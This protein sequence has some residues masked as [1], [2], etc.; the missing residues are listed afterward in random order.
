MQAAG[1][2]Y[3]KHLISLFKESA[4]CFVDHILDPNMLLIHSCGNWFLLCLFVLL[5]L[6]METLITSERNLQV[7]TVQEPPVSQSK[8]Q[9][10]YVPKKLSRV[11]KQTM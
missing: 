9:L 7:L 10:N 3:G 6:C 5:E 11:L 1:E 2:H 4:V 8:H